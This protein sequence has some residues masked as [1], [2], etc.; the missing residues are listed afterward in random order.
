MTDKPTAVTTKKK[1]AEGDNAKPLLHDYIKAIEIQ[2]ARIAD[3][4]DEV[5]DILERAKENGFSKMA[6]REVVR[7]RARSDKEK[8]AKKSVELE[9]KRYTEM[10]S[11]LPLW[12]AAKAA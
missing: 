11:D 5:K 7:D 12:E 8:A 2:N 9:V 3:A 1:A 6:L 10:C 4:K